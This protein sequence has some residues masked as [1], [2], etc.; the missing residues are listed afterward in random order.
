MP[1]S[2]EPLA[3]SAVMG[4]ELLMPRG[5]YLARSSASSASVDAWRTLREVARALP[6]HGEGQGWGS[7]GHSSRYDPGLVEG[8]RAGVA[9][10]RPGRAARVFEP[11]VGATNRNFTVCWAG[12]VFFCT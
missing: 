2:S 6:I 8:A 5:M 12:E 9:T 4:W 7:R 1:H 11:V 3:R 10:L